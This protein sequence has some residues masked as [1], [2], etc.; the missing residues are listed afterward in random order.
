MI[1]NIPPNLK[2]FLSPLGL[3]G[4]VDQGL[5][6][7]E[8]NLIRVKNS[9]ISFYYPESVLY[10]SFLC[11]HLA[12]GRKTFNDL[13]LLTESVSDQS[14][15]KVYV[16]S[17]MA[18][19]KNQNET[20]INILKSRVQGP[21][22][23]PFHF[24]DYLLGVAYLN[25]LDTNCISFFDHFLKTSQSP[26]FQKDAHLRLSWAYSLLGKEELAK[27]HL[28]EC[29]DETQ[30]TLTERDKQALLEAR[31]G[32]QNKSLLRAH[33]LF[34][35]GY[36]DASF[37]NLK[38]TDS[39]Q[40]KNFREKLE[41]TYRKARILESEG[42]YPQAIYFHKKTLDLGKEEPYYFAANSCLHLG[43]IYETLRNPVLSKHYYDTCLKM[44]EKE[45]K[46]SIDQEAQIG[47]HR[48]K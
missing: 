10:Y 44:N 5:S 42:K 37:S 21:D 1:G 23:S 6:T 11:A 17:L 8:S 18:I 25:R 28:L 29:L 34:D 46:N 26:N 9:N 40:L 35:G 48:L 20:A 15:L 38:N 36:F 22:Y 24:L 33:L 3:K 41:F 19:K 45:Y 2:F 39:A 7:I 30:A 12:P 43:M 27:K 32:I 13:T 14:L 4:E 47:L 16:T 31:K